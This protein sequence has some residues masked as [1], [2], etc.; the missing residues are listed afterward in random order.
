MEKGTL[1][2]KVEDLY[3]TAFI[4]TLR[5]VVSSS[6]IAFMVSPSLDLSRKRVS[7]KRV[8]SKVRKE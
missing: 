4:P 5:A 2:L 1:L 8:K 6:L 3:N 7:I